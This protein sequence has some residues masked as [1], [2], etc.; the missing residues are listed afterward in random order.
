MYDFVYLQID[1][2]RTGG[3]GVGTTSSPDFFA[4]T[5]LSV[6]DIIAQV[7]SKLVLH[8]ISGSGGDASRGALELFAND[9]VYKNL[10]WWAQLSVRLNA[11]DK[12]LIYGGRI[13]RA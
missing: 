6:S 4:S 1:I 7:P 13:K 3:V 5:D 8:V 11:L 2:Y 12:G 9:K 10:S